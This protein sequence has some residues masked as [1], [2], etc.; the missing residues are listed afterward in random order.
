MG[1][2][3]L[4]GGPCSKTISFDKRGE[5]CRV[6]RCR[7]VPTAARSR[8]SAGGSVLAYICCVASGPTVVLLIST[9]QEFYMSNSS[10]NPDQ[11]QNQG[12]KSKNPGQQNQGQ[13]SPGQQNQGGR[14]G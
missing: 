13:P 14:S 4:S 12:G 2:S 8:P 9:P 3:Y 10:R 1:E 7:L 11:D 5:Q 6:H